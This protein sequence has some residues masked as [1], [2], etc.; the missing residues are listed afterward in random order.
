[1][2]GNT[3]IGLSEWPGLCTCYD[4]WFYEAAYMYIALPLMGTNVKETQSAT[5]NIF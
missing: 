5:V 4:V 3:L 1:M 2:T